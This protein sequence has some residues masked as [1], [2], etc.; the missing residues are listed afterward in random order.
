MHKCVHTY[1]GITHTH[2]NSCVHI[3]NSYENGSQDKLNKNS[4]V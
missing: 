4:I 2:T 1:A 3:A